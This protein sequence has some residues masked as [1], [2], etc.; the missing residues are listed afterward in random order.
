MGN[1]AHI[2]MK[3]QTFNF[4]SMVKHDWY[5]F[6]L[7]FLQQYFSLILKCSFSPTKQHK[8]TNNINL[9]MT[10]DCC[11]INSIDNFYR[12]VRTHTSLRIFVVCAWNV[13]FFIRINCHEIPN[14]MQHFQLVF[15]FN[16]PLAGSN[17]DFWKKK[18][19]IILSVLRISGHINNCNK[20]T[21]TV[22]K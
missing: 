15:F 19:C 22:A 21:H 8:G 9:I 5:R 17:A 11:A 16:L 10:F 20:W 7:N 18:N 6:E 2:I 3:K 14:S 1:H 4:I 13:H 12:F